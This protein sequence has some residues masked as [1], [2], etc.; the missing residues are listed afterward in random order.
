MLCSFCNQ[1]VEETP[2]LSERDFIL[3]W[4]LMPANYDEAHALMP[5]LNSTPE[6]TVTNIINFLNDKRGMSRQN[7]LQF[8]INQW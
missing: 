6:S 4:N 8:I 3:L 1:Q 7:W 5:S 2:T